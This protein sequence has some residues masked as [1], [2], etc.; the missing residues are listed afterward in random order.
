MGTHPKSYDDRSRLMI[1]IVPQIGLL[2][3]FGLFL[4]LGL[5]VMAAIFFFALV[6]QARHEIQDDEG[7][8]STDDPQDLV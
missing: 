2:G 1:S 8:P 7:A 4:A 5:V 6:N 3:G